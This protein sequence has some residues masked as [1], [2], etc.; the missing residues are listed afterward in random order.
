MNLDGNKNRFSGFADIY[1]NARPKPPKALVDISEKYCDNLGKATIADLGCGTGQSTLFWKKYSAKVY[2][3][4]PNFDMIALANKNN[5]VSNIEYIQSI[6]SETTLNDESVNIVTCSQ[7]L[8]W[9]DPFSTYKEVYRILKPQGL[10]LAYDCDW[11]PTFNWK[12][13]NEWQTLFNNVKKLEKQHNTFDKVK[14]WNKN[15][16]LTRIQNSG[17]FQFTKEVVIHNEEL[18]NAERF[19]NLAL[20]QGQVQTLLKIELSEEEVGLN[21]FRSNIKNI[22]GDSIYKWLFSY[23]I[24][25]GISSK[26]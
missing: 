12:A 2:G 4:E 26:Q 24:R 5:S 22:L 20:S 7:A 15:D 18:G 16:H 17:V 23:R 11:P 8:H 19:I 6:S 14:H 21:K 13:E 25:L 1:D 3:I 10:F 9:M